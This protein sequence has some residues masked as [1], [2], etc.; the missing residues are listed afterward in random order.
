M[1]KMPSPIMETLLGVDGPK[2]TVKLQ[3]AAMQHA[4]KDDYC[5]REFAE[6][7]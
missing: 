6:K 3:I 7:P 1:E 5:Q 2:K 4:Q